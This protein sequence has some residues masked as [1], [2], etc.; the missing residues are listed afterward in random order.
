ML[1]AIDLARAQ[2]ADQQ[3]LA[4]EDIQWQETVMIVIAV[5]KATFLLT[6]NGVI[7]RIEVQNQAFG[8]TAERGD[9]LIDQDFMQAPG[10]RSI[11]AILPTAQRRGAGQF[12][13]AL[14]GCL[15][16]RVFPQCLVVIEIFVAQGQTIQALAQQTQQ[17]MLA[18][19]LPAWVVNGAGN[20][21]AQPQPLIGLLQLQL[22]LIH[23]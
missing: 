19:C 13:A 2:V 10:R 5:A 15:Q 14:D 22:S 3:L 23:I 8:W 11:R 9:E 17:I 16:G 12:C 18:T 21:S 7:G 20:G 1:G 6:M 4:A